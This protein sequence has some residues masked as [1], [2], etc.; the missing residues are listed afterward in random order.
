MRIIYIKKKSRRNPDLRY[1]PY[2][3][4]TRVTAVK[5]RC[6]KPLTNGTSCLNDKNNYSIS[7]L[8]MQ[9]F[10]QKILFFSSSNSFM[11]VKRSRDKGQL[12]WP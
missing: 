11:A 1:S 4:R 2:G 6:L 5:R 9:D 8:G 3:I 7:N 12:A 10:F